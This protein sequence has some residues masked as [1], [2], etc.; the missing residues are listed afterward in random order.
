MLT[1][2]QALTFDRTVKAEPSEVFRAL[3]N[4][5][6][7][8]DWLCNAAQIETRKGGRV[9]LW[10]NKG[11]YAAGMFTDME[12]DEKLAFTWQ[13]SGDPAATEVRVTLHPKGE[14]TSVSITHGGVGSGAEWAESAQRIKRIWEDGL[15]NLQS[16]LETGI[17]LRLA[18]RPM[19]GLNGG[20]LLGPELVAR[21]GVPVKEGIWLAGLV[22]GMGAQAAGLQKDDVVVSL[23]GRDITTF[24]SFTTALEGHQAGDKVPVI[25]Y[26]GPERH[27]VTVELS[28]RPTPEL[29]AT[30]EE[31]ARAMK[32]VNAALD[33]E[34][35]ALFEGV[36]EAE[37]DYR[38]APNEWN[39]KEILGHLIGSER[40]VHGWIASI[41]SDTTDVDNIFNSNGNERVSS[42]A[43]VY[44]PLPALVEELKRSD[45]LTMAMVASMPAAAVARKHLFNPL[46]TW[47]TTFADHHREHFAEI[48]GLL[49][50]ARK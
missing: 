18:R 44:S 34:L 39:S 43:A 27:E 48:K 24:Q 17:D 26:R 36:S 14:G 25:F 49:E 3:T 32:E 2:Q 22:D 38:P 15:E 35:D 10:W 47:L 11:Y 23:A 45:A 31:L 20:D 9:Y 1:Q 4:T 28:R 29:P 50:A 42:L 21:L 12:R 30:T 33:A 37:A 8:R 13:G 5:S 7:L 46:A 41:I 40:D 16:I 6:A 19:F